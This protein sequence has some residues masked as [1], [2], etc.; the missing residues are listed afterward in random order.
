MPYALCLSALCVQSA[1][2]FTYNRNRVGLRLSGHA[3]GGA[4][5]P[6]Y[7]VYDYR[8]RAQAN[9]AV[10][11]GWTLGAVYSVERTGVDREYFYN[12]IFIFTE[13]PYGRVE[14]GWTESVAAKL[15]VGLPDV[16]SLRAN[17]TPL[18]Y[19]MTGARNVIA[20]PVA[21]GTRYAF[22]ATTVTVPTRPVQ[23]G[24]SVSPFNTNFD[25]ATDIGI[26]YRMPHGRTKYSV[27][28]GAGYIDRPN[29]LS[30]DSYAPN[31]TAD[32]R[33]QLALGTNIQHRSWNFGIT[34]RG[35]YDNNPITAPS[36]GLQGGIGASYDFLNWSGS[37]S[38]IFSAVGIWDNNPEHPNSYLTH[39]GLASLRYKID[40]YF[41]VFT[42]GGAV[43]NAGDFSPFITAGIRASF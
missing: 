11:N 28:I 30:A 38:Y 17:S 32:S 16:G 39:T 3:T 2:A 24:M 4:G 23:V 1:D 35:I 20:N 22:R 8:I 33:Y 26:R 29:N 13:S 19:D 34:A 41:S 14:L 18:F 10:W 6:E 21:T 5:M 25:S 9:Y 36:D 15:G 40:Q 7:T 27:S 42:S 43:I 37:L 31:V 12:D